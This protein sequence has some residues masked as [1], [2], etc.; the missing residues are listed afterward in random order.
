MKKWL[1]LFV[2]MCLLTGC[3]ATQTF[4]TVGD[5]A[6]IGTAAPVKQMQLSLPEEAAVPT[7][8]SAAG[9][10]YL[11]DGYMIAVQ[12]LAGG[13][14]GRT[15][16][17]LTG[18]TEDRLQMIRT[19]QAEMVR[20]DLSWSAAGE[21]GDQICRCVL[22]DDGAMH[23]AVTVMAPAENAGSLKDTWQDLM[24]SVRLVSTD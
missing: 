16:K 5:E 8:E 15:L 2:V 12:T 7:M 22:L 14:L 23:Y 4:E 24:A 11:C 3:S 6:L 1:L 9:S 18:F 13:D 19:E 21:Q 10:I 17:T 20:Y